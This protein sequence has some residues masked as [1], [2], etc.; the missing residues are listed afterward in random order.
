MEITTEVIK[1]LRDLTGV[2]IMQCKKALEEAEGDIEKAKIVL[3]KQSGAAASKKAER[4]LKSGVVSSYIHAGGTVGSMIELLCETDFVAKN[5][6]FQRLA[7]D[8][9]MQVAAANP[10]FVRPEDIQE[11]EKEKA[12][13]IFMG[14][15]KDKPA[16]IQNK[17]V[18][19]KLDAYFGERTLIKQAFIKDP[20]RTIESL[21]QSGI[22]KFGEKI[23]IGRIAR[24]G[25]LG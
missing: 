14:E 16:E 11:T 12:R 10:D 19:G 13:E 21:I 15:A 1:K 17:I 24:F 8:I 4:E 22:Q 23:D 20:E 9:A 7:K 5:E 2:S 25:L 6:E 3:R 18:E